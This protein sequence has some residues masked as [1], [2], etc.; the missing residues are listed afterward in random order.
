MADARSIDPACTQRVQ[1]FE[2]T[3]VSEEDQR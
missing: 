1:E 3:G 2:M